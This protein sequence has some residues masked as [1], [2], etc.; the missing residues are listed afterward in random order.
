MWANPAASEPVKAYLKAGQEEQTRAHIVPKQ[1]KPIFI[2]KVRSMAVYISRELK[3]SDLTLQE[4][5]VLQRDQALLKLQ[6]LAGDRASDVA[7]VLSQEVKKLDDSGFVFNHTFGKILRGGSNKC[8]TFVLKRCNDKIVCPFSGLE[9][10]TFMKNHGISLKS[11][12]LFRI[13]TE[14]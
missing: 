3:R 13:I 8:N 14:S 7:I 10:Y 12:Y 1:A 11:V 6:F 5:F 4:K 2:N 9:S